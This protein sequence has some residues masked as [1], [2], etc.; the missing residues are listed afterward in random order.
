MDRKYTT[1]TS[2]ADGREHSIRYVTRCWCEHSEHGQ[3][4]LTNAPIC[5]E[6]LPIGP[7]YLCEVHFLELYDVDPRQV[8]A[9]E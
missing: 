3:S 4:K 7:R 1:A 5:I 6:N 8:E 2:K 9:Y